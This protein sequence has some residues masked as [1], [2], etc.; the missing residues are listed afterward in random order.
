MEA[1]QQMR[2]LLNKNNHVLEK[3]EPFHN[4]GDI[5]PVIFTFLMTVHKLFHQCRFMFRA[6]V[7]I[8]IISVA[9]TK[10]WKAESS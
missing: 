2:K 7:K 8:L 5:F 6:N 4:L 9:R 3:K 1:N 10:E